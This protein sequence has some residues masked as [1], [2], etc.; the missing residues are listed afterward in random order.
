MPWHTARNTES[1]S[2]WIAVNCYQHWSHH[3]RERL[4]VPFHLAGGWGSPAWYHRH[5]SE[6]FTRIFR[7]PSCLYG[8]KYYF[9]DETSV[10]TWIWWIH[11][12]AVLFNQFYSFWKH[13]SKKFFLSFFKITPRKLISLEHL[14]TILVVPT[15]FYPLWV[16]MSSVKCPIFGRT[17]VRGCSGVQKCQTSNF[18]YGE[19]SDSKY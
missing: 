13:T 15:H 2:R 16:Q 9:V 19:Y 6:S 3:C 1:I 14:K 11:W 4:A 17:A 8:W 18:A 7:L 12:A 10:Y 5:L